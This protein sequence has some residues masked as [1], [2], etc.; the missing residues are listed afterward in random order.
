MN[1][2][3]TE[4]INYIESI[5]FILDI[6]DM[7]WYTKDYNQRI[8]VQKYCKM[9]FSIFYNKS[10]FSDGKKFTT[11]LELKDLLNKKDLN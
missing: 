7:I 10:G 6:E 3:N 2:N 9:P 1:Q 8:A 5:G 11:L 4:I